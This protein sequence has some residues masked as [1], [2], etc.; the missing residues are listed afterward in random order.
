[1]WA[2]T[3][4]KNAMARAFGYLAV[5]LVSFF[6]TLWFIDKRRDEHSPLLG[7]KVTYEITAEQLPEVCATAKSTIQFKGQ[8]CDVSGDDLSVLWS[9]IA[10]TTNTQPSCGP[11]K[12]I[13][14]PR[15]EGD[16]AYNARFMGSCGIKPDYF[17]TMPS[18]FG[19]NSLKASAD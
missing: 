3:I 18:T 4:G 10:N 12:V 17:K 19:P 2:A 9:S 15:K 1:L 16:P 11:E 6:V 5:V 14:W 13:R 7:T 8:I